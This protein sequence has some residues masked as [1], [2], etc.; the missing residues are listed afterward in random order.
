MKSYSYKIIQVVWYKG[1]HLAKSA[2][3]VATP[4]APSPAGVSWL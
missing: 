2:I 3:K 1:R 4:H